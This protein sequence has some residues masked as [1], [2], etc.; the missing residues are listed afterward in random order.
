MLNPLKLHIVL[1]FLFI[2]LT[3]FFLFSCSKQQDENLVVY[4]R[5]GEETLTSK[6]IDS[7]FSSVPLNEKNIS[8]SIGSWVD[9]K[10]LFLASK[11]EGYD[12]DINLIKKRNSFFEDLM[13]SSFIENQTN[14]R[15]AVKNKEIRE[16]YLK[17][18]KAFKR[19]AAVVLVDVFLAK[20]LE[21]GIKIKRALLSGS[22][23]KKTSMSVF[24]KTPAKIKQGRST[25]KI[26]LALFN[27]KQDV[28]GPFEKEDGFHVYEI[29]KRYS[30]GSV[31]G[32]EEVYDE[33]YQRIYKTKLTKTHKDVL[34]SLKKSVNVFIN[35][36]YQ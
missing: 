21:Q 18:K 2:F 4:A 33:I 16:Y 20:N 22:D 17:N 23:E 25:K 14:K 15:I 13:I 12:K 29:I 19:R 11:K 1:S 30:R 35:P 32:L 26:D 5:V 34:D 7:V 3:T 27:N 10:V 31:S 6:N 36:K 9:K 28:A 24:K 8:F